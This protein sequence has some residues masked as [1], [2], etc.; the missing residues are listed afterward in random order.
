MKISVL[1][2]SV[3]RCW[4]KLKE[5]LLKYL[6]SEP[7]TI[8][9]LQRSNNSSN[10]QRILNSLVCL[11]SF[12]RGY[13]TT[14]SIIIYQTMKKTLALFFALSSLTAISAEAA[15][16]LTY[17]TSAVGN[18]DMAMNGFCLSLGSDSLVPADGTSAS[19]LTGNVK[20]NSLT[21]KGAQ[22]A[23]EDVSDVTYGFLVLNYTDD[24]VLGWSTNTETTA[25]GTDLTFNF[26]ELDGTDLILD[27]SSTYRFIAV[28]EAVMNLIQEDTSK[29]YTYSGTTVG[30][31]SLSSTETDDGSI[32][33]QNGLQTVGVYSQYSDTASD[34]CALLA[35]GKSGADSAVNVM[36]PVLTNI[37]VETVP[38]PATATL[39]LLGLAGL[40]L[41]R[42]R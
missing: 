5:A 32:A 14:L 19:S 9:R 15:T 20:L 10:D 16:A 38:E 27:A 36:A 24:A 8:N 7:F 18:M 26:S 29:S 2:K 39:S 23:N 30:G 12:K 6:N 3:R 25:V 13:L 4:Q 1:W 41:R 40:M 34:D 37:Q 42:R 22:S 11:A 33:I 28:S 35:M 31:A 17:Q 21:V